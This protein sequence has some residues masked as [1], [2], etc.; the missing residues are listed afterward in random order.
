MSLF[1]KI[2]SK[3]KKETLDK[4]LEKS[5]SN[6]FSK[7]SKAVAG[8]TEVDEEV[9]DDLE[10]VLVS[11]DVGLPPP[12]RSLTALKKG[13]PAIN[14]SAPTNSTRSLEKKSPACFLKLKAAKPRNL[15][16]PIRSLM[17]SWLLA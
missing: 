5:Q 4:G 2:F 1:K 15:R 13:W 12:L 17:W 11:S 14:T 3:E 7:L 9:F 8:K 6:F 10:D 16:S